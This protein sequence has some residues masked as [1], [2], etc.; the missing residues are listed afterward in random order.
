MKRL[1]SHILLFA[2][3]VVSPLSFTT[4]E[5][6]SIYI[7]VTL[8]TPLQESR[9][10]RITVAHRVAQTVPST[11]IARNPD[12]CIISLPILPAIDS[13]REIEHGRAPPV[14]PSV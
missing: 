8:N 3:L 10:N 2:L 11:V 1:L 9:K 14:V 12:K 6:P 4:S 13:H 7:S 5:I